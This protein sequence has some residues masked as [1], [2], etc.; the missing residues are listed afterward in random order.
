MNTEQLHTFLRSTEEQYIKFMDIDSF[1]AYRIE[2]KSISVD[3]VEQRGYGQLATALYNPD[4][5]EHVL[6]MFSDYEIPKYL[7]FHEFTHILDDEMLVGNDLK[8]Y[9][10]LFGY[11]EYHASQIELL[12]LLGAI[13]RSQ[14]SSFTMD[15]EITTI[16]GKTNV[17]EYVHLK[18]QHAIDLFS[19]IDFPA[20]KNALIAALNVLFNYWGLRSICEMYASDYTENIQNGVFLQHISTL[21]FSPINRLMH[22]WLTEEQI[23]NSCILFLQLYNSVKLMY[24][25]S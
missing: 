19:R 21:H 22:G 9:N 20:D 11:A 4:S 23:N 3:L 25:L 24:R 10:G 5:R 14:V 16:T 12:Q 18:Q 7:L 8:K 2:E 17:F 15:T 13:S 1:P 6:Q